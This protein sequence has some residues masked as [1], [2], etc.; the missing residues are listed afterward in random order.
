MDAVLLVRHEIYQ[1]IKC[2][3]IWE[4]TATKRNFYTMKSGFIFGAEP[5]FHK[6]IVCIQFQFATSVARTVPL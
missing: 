3:Y 4:V 5:Y 1:G 6:F 2:N